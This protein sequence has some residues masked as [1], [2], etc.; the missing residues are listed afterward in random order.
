MSNDSILEIEDGKPLNFIEQIVVDD[1]QSGKY[2]EIVTRFPPEPNGYLHIGHAK[3][4][5]L[6]FGLLQK[7]PG[8]CYLRFDDT[9]PLKEEDEYVQAI[10]E[11]IRWLGFNWCAIT[12]SS[13]YY[14]ELYTFAIHLIEKGL[15]YVDSLSADDIRNYRGT[16]QKPGQ[17]SPF[18]DR[19]IAENLD[20]FI[21]MRK[22]EFAD[23]E[24]VLRAK[25]DM[26]SPNINMRDPVIYRI[27]HAHHQRTG[28][29]WCIY[30]MYDYAHPLS[31]ALEKITHSLCSLEFQD[32]RPI[33][34]WF[35]DNTPVQSKPIQTEFARLNISHSVTSKRK[36]KQLVD[37]NIVFSWEDPRMPTIKGMRN[38]GYPAQAIRKFCE[39]IGVS[40]SDSVIDFSVLEDCVRYELNKTAKR[41]LAVLDP[42]KIIIENYP[43]NQEELLEADFYPHDDNKVE[44]RTLPFARE[45]YIERSDFM[46]EPS[47]KFFRLSVGKEVRLRHAYVIKC[48]SLVRDSTGKIIELRCTFDKDTLGK[49]PQDRKVKGVIHWVSVKHAHPITV[50]QFDRL[51]TD[52]N[53]GQQEDFKQFINENSLISQQAFCE[54]SV[55]DEPLNSVIQFERIGYYKVSDVEKTKVATMHRVVELKS[56]WDKIKVK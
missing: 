16:L 51:F 42:I 23:G 9:N 53:P 24:H 45:I 14:E 48:E 25:I 19:S 26:R 17:N 33:Y 50:L 8:K 7:Y 55:A 47:S 13:D 31:D 18:R 38:R 21:R 3:A 41:V 6:N 20:L 5:C 27:R 36:L 35:V 54:M 28:D 15:A 44:I 32:H 11:D 46:E 56:T 2:K 30:P 12:H 40:R 22:G 1:L 43:E 39:I 10:I 49:N 29:K 52:E 4:I 37:D 34:D